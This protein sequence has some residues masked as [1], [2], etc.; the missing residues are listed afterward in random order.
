MTYSSG[1]H[2][3]GM[4][5]VRGDPEYPILWLPAENHQ[6]IISANGHSFSI[7]A[8]FRII[9][10]IER[11]NTGAAL[12]VKSLIEE[13]AGTTRYADVEYEAEPEGI[14]TVLEKLYTLHAITD[15]H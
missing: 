7:P 15:G 9:R 11:L 12:R 1:L 2:P 8:D 10:L 3:A 13:H 4:S 6:I 5:T 14:R